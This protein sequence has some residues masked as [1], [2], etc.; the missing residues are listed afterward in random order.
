MTEKKGNKEVPT[1]KEFKVEQLA[2]HLTNKKQLLSI[3]DIAGD[4]IW[5]RWV[6]KNGVKHFDEF[7]DFELGDYSQY[8]YNTV[9]R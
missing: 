6:D 4:A 9:R 1:K 5:C 3:V 2:V 8:Y 7:K